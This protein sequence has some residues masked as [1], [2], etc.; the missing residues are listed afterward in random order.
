L[1]GTVRRI[2]LL[3][4]VV[5]SL[6]AWT[7]T[8][9]AAKPTIEHLRFEG[10]VDVIPAGAPCSFPVTVTASGHLR[11]AT[12]VDRD[13]NVTRE[14]SN[15]S[16]VLT[17]SANGNSFVTADRGVDRVTTNPDGTITIFGTGI[18]LRVK[19]VYQDIGLWI[20]TLDPQTGDIVSVE[21]HGSFTGGFLGQDAFICSAL[22]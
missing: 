9:H 6:L 4:A 18:H 10:Q 17:V 3:A 5:M 13:G 1:E 14:V 20:I 21:E 8:A 22:S 19:G 7:A 12:Y 2:S 11:I 16:Q 15:P